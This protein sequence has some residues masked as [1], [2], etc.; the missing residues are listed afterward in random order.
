MTEWDDQ[1]E[2]EARE[3]RAF[4]GKPRAREP[5]QPTRYVAKVRPDGTVLA[6]ATRCIPVVPGVAFERGVEY[7]LVEIRLPG[8]EWQPASEDRVWRYARTLKLAHDAVRR[9]M[10]RRAERAA[11]AE[12]RSR[13]VEEARALL[14]AIEVSLP[15]ADALAA[16]RALLAAAEE[17]HQRAA[18]DLCAAREAVDRIERAMKLVGR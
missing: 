10:A 12:E 9:F 1:E 18:D 4:W 17:R 14:A 6:R 13:H 7:L 8:N 16:E 15:V 5:G 2:R 11:E 3:A